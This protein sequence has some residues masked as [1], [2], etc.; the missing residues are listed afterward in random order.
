MGIKT[1][2]P[3]C[4]KE[5]PKYKKR[6]IIRKVC[7]NNCTMIIH[8]FTHEQRV[9]AQKNRFEN[10]IYKSHQNRIARG[11][12]EYKEWRNKVFEHDNY[13]CQKCGEHSGNGHAVN[14]H[15]HHIKPFATFPELRYEASNGITLCSSCHRKEHDHVFI[16]RTPFRILGK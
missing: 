3:V 7:S 13:T 1:L 16:G 10:H 2:C 5:M 6:G 4:G 11:K 9:K 12:P 14:L 8:P 15:P